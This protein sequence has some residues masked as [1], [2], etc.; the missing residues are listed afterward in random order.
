V[1]EGLRLLEERDRLYKARMAELQKEIILEIE[2]SE[3]GE[4]YD[5]E[6]VIQ[7]LRKKNQ[8]RMSQSV[9]KR[10]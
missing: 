8:Q 4:L 9:S 1:S 10:F 7:E 6:T 5:G 3:R 2:S